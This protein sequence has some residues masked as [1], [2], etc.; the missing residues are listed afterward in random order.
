MDPVGQEIATKRVPKPTV[1]A[2][3]EKLNQLKGARKAKY[4]YLTKKMKEIDVLM[5]DYSNAEEVNAK[6]TTDFTNVYMEF[7]AVNE[8]IRAELNDREAIH[9]QKQWYEPKFVKLKTFVEKVEKWL[10]KVQQQADEAEIM[11][12]EVEPSDSAS[13]ISVKHSSVSQS[14]RSVSSVS[15]TASSA[16]LKVEAERAALVAR[17]EALKQKLEI[18]REEALLKARKEE[19][20]LKT[21]IAAANAKLEVLTV[22]ESTCSASAVSRDGMTPYVNAASHLREGCVGSVQS[23]R[24]EI[25]NRPDVTQRIMYQHQSERDGRSHLAAMSSKKSSTRQSGVADI[26]DLL[27]VMERQNEITELLVKQQRVSTLPPLNVPVFNGDPLEFGF[28]MKAFEHGIEERTDSNRDRLHFLEQYTH[29]RPKILVRSCSHMHPDRGYVEAKKLLNKHFGNEYTIASAYIERALKWPVI[30]SE[31]GEALTELAV[32]LT[33]CCNTVDSMDYIEE[34]DSP[35]NMRA[36]ISKLPFKLR[37]KWRGVAC[38]IQ[39]RSERRA[40]FSDLV[41]F[42]DKQAK[43]ASHPL[44]GNI[45]E[46]TSSRDGSKAS[47]SKSASRVKERKNIFATNVKPMPKITEQ[48]QKEKESTGSTEER[49]C[50]FCHRTGHNLEFCKSIKQKSHREKLEFLKSKGLCFGCLSQGHLSKGCQKRLICQTCT[51]K[52]PTILHLN[53]EA[54][55]PSVGEIRYAKEPG[56]SS[57]LITESETCG[58]TGAGEAACALSIVP[59]K[60]RCVRSNKTVESYAFLDPGSTGTFCTEELM[61]DLKVTGKKANIVLRTMGKEGTV[62]THVVKGLE[63]SSLDENNFLELPQVFSQAEIPVKKENIPKQRDV[64]K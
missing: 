12:A 56:T 4:A 6:T 11:N 19:W 9:D 27:N 38:D 33:S 14:R 45:Q 47:A 39:E 20:E 62:S 41:S 60:V 32:F 3:E 10:T 61:R 21:A 26:G 35:T 25:R 59:V 50:L 28:F 24:A 29:G 40:R 63:V 7:C 15:T 64:D 17:A 18:E 44:F 13:M 58:C 23:E 36:I 55:T 37:D 43:I 57:P 22:K 16:R 30:R 2:L 51:L 34:M 48:V 31:D 42:V 54:L 8:A 5:E 52:H 46:H 49:H 1:K 53:K